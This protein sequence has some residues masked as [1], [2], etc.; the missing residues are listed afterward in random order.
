MFLGQTFTFNFSNNH[1]MMQ[2]SV[3]AEEKKKFSGN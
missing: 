1:A 2:F 3:F